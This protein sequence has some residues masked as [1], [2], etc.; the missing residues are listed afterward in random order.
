[1]QSILD[2]LKGIIK[3]KMECEFKLETTSLSGMYF[4][5][6]IANGVH[7]GRGSNL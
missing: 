1:M 3:N 2:F 5:V 4:N 7:S 6:E